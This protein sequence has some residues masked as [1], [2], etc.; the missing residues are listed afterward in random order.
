MDSTVKI[1]NATWK[2]TQTK[3]K[4]MVPTE[5]N[6]SVC[7]MD[8]LGVTGSNQL[9][10]SLLFMTLQ[11]GIGNTVKVCSFSLDL[12]FIKLRYII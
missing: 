2:L 8:L 1:G 4:W 7:Q 5:S 10:Y 6:H 3:G 9:K 11:A 12:S